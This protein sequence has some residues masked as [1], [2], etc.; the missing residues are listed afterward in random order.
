MRV[1]LF[2]TPVNGRFFETSRSSRT[3]PADNAGAS[4]SIPRV[5]LLDGL[6]LERVLDEAQCAGADGVVGLHGGD[7]RLADEGFECACVGH[8]GSFRAIKLAVRL[9]V[10]CY[11]R[12]LGLRHTLK[13]LDLHLAF[14]EDCFDLELPAHGLNVTPQG[15]NVYIRALL[16]AGDGALIDLQYS[17]K[18]DLSKISRLPELAESHHARGSFYIPSYAF[19]DLR[20]EGSTNISP[21]CGHGFALLL[22]LYLLSDMPS[23]V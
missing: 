6:V 11:Q 8:G 14:G 4:S 10:R 5:S 9:G 18:A 22:F 21:F 19:L 20:W 16:Q 2:P 23:R 15:R 1:P 7:D 3:A 12:V 13:L 17:G